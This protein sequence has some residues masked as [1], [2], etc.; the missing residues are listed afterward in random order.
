M[1]CIV[2]SSEPPNGALNLHFNDITATSTSTSTTTSIKLTA[3]QTL[4][5]VVLGMENKLKLTEEETTTTTMTKPSSDSN[6]GVVEDDVAE[7]MTGF[8]GPEKRLEVTFTLNPHRPRGLRD[9]SKNQWQELL[10]LAKCTIISSTS[11][12][13]IDSFVLSESSLFV[14]SNKIVLKT[15]GT[16]TLLNCLDKLEEYGKV[17]GSEIEFLLFTRKN[18]N[19]PEKQLHPHRNFEQE[20]SILNKKFPN[21]LAHVLGPVHQQKQNIKKK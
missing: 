20:V 14:S 15:C 2:Y 6:S 21:G 13:H 4:S 17:C 12:S 11:N 3:S 10:D 5:E 1:S 18:F 19:F 8:E 7:V 16:T 9:I